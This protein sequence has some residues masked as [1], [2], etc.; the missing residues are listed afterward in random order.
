MDLRA[1]IG[2]AEAESVNQKQPGYASD[3]V[4]FYWFPDIGLA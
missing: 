2:K 3:V 4:A 1:I